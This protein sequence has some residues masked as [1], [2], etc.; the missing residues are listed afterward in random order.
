MYRPLLKDT[1]G[2]YA[3]K[4]RMRLTEGDDNRRTRI[5]VMEEDGQS[6]RTG[7]LEDLQS[8]VDITPIVSFTQLYFR[9]ANF[10]MCMEASDVLVWPSHIT[11]ERG[12]FDFI[13]EELPPNPVNNT[14]FDQFPMQ[15]L[16]YQTPSGKETG[17]GITVFISKN[18]REKFTKARF[19]LPPSRVPFEIREGFA[20]NGPRTLTLAINSAQVQEFFQRLDDQNVIF[21]TDHQ[22]SWFGGSSAK[23]SMEDVRKMYRTCLYT[24]EEGDFEPTL[25][26]KLREQGK[27]TDTRVFIFVPKEGDGNHSWRPGCMEDITIQSVVAPIISISSLHFS[28]K[29]GMS[30]YASDLLVF[31]S[32][33]GARLGISRFPKILTGSMNVT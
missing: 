15:E 1:Q 8:R 23:S 18:E 29:F 16:H 33:S 9:D 19:Q 26:L 10:G 11:P 3:P 20:G 32:S 7:T 30:F 22:E 4:I 5:F 13:V 14:M 12:E 6:W 17:N 28:E 2:K 24:Q 21:T 25:N 31:P 27:P